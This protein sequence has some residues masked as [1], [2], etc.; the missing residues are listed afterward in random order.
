LWLN[1]SG[2]ATFDVAAPATGRLRE[3]YAYTDDALLPG[4]VLGTVES[5]GD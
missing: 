5:S 4:Q 3:K 2:A 1:T